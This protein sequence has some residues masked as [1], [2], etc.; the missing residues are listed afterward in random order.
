V[1]SAG[2]LDAAC[3]QAAGLAGAALERFDF[4]DA[5]AAIWAIADKA[6][7]FVNRVRPWDLARAERDGDGEARAALDAALRT[8]LG[9]C[10]ALGHELRPFLPDAAGRIAAQCTPGQ[11]GRLPA[12]RPVFRRL[13]PRPSAGTPGVTA[14]R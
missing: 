3:R 8:L 4:R 5:T 1:P 14:T 7:R 2:D 10:Q 6:N 12:P 11:D 9:A 13:A